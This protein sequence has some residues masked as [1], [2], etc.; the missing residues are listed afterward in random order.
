VW[1][2]GNL[3]NR[4]TKPLNA[5]AEEIGGWEW[6]EGDIPK[7]IISSVPVSFAPK[8]AFTFI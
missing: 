6:R 1:F 7:K 5:D 8:L 3:T 4:I 2:V